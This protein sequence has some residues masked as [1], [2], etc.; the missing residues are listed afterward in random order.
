[1]RKALFVTILAALTIPA[2]AQ[3]PIFVGAQVGTQGLGVSA[4]IDLEVVS[5]SGELGFLPISSVSFENDGT[6]YKLDVKPL[7]G[8]LMVNVGPGSS[9]FVL[10]AGLHF[11][12]FNGDGQATNL[13]GLVDIGDNSYPAPGID[14]LK[15]D[16]EFGGIAPAVMLGLRR[17]GF[18]FGLGVAI[19]GSPKFTSFATGTLKDDPQFLADLAS[20]VA[21]IQ[22]DLDRIPVLPILRIGWQIGVSGQ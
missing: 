6:E 13:R 17:E 22:D 18:N 5:V 11:G 19:T 2:A 21:D 15:V 1:M 9:R 10:S 16:F 3:N 20:D 12:G 8:L 4:E 14:E 7:S